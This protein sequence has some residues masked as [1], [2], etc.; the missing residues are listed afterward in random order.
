M[1]CFDCA[2]SSLFVDMSKHVIIGLQ[3]HAYVYE[4][5]EQV[6]ECAAIQI[7]MHAFACVAMVTSHASLD[8]LLRLSLDMLHASRKPDS[9]IELSRSLPRAPTLRFPT[10]NSRLTSLL[11]EGLFVLG[12]NAT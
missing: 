11:R 12:V 1:L 10:T 5:D 7:D 8:W 6:L 2:R 4:S 9:I 3:F